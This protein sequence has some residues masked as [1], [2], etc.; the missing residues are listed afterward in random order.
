MSSTTTAPC[1]TP[2]ATPGPSSS[3]VRRAS[4]TACWCASSVVT[5]FVSTLSGA[6]DCAW[7]A[8]QSANQ[9]VAR[10]GAGGNAICA[11]AACACSAVIAP[12]SA[13][14]VSTSRARAAATRGSVRGLNREGARGR[15]ASIAACHSDTCRAEMPKYIR[16]AASMP[17]VPEPRYTRLSQISRI[18]RLLKVCSSHSVSSSSCTLRR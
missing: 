5:S 15:P 10:G 4:A 18:S 14:A 1:V 9:P 11:S 13:M 17:Q 7:S 8:T 2:A 12:V 6:S 16:A 3:A